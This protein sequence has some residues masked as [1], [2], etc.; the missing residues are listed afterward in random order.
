MVDYRGSTVED[1]QLSPAL[2]L[3]VS[4]SIGAALQIAYERDFS[5]LPL[6]STSS[7]ASLHGWLDVDALKPLAEAGK[8]DLELPLS[9]LSGS[10]SPAGEKGEGKLVKQFQRGRKYEVI[11]PFTP[12]E[13]LERFLSSQPNVGFAL[14]TD[15]ARKFVLGLVTREDLSKFTARRF[16]SAGSPETTTVSLPASSSLLGGAKGGRVQPLVA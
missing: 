5:I 6:H 7:R 15:A 3:P 12:L 16:P 13:D 10:S 9:D 2:V 11:T 4:T 1:L 14:V 8:I